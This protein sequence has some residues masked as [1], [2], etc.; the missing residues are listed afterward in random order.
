MADLIKKQKRA[1][2][3]DGP[4]MVEAMRLLRRR[5]NKL[6]KAKREADEITYLNIVA[7]MDMMTILLVF[8]L[9]SVSFSAATVTTSKDLQ[10]PKSSANDPLKESVKVFISKVN[11]IVEDTPVAEIKDGFIVPLFVDKANKNLI[12]SLKEALGREITRYA[13]LASALK[14][15]EAGADLTIM[16]DTETTFDTI[17]KVFSTASQS[18][19]SGEGGKEKCGFT[20]YR[21]T[22]LKKKPQ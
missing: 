4:D 13:E 20:K 21:L 5:Q 14:T 2:Y 1:D 3:Q 7:M 8:L 9:Q 11:I 17:I 16:A 10:L 12:P 22:V 6:N 19:S 18:T 15:L